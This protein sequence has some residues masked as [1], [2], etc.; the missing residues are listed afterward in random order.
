M[1]HVRLVALAVL[2]G[3]LGG[4]AS[5]LQIQSEH[6]P[7]FDFS[8][9]RTYEWLAVAQPEFGSNTAPEFRDPRFEAEA[10]DPPIR[11]AVDRELAARGYQRVT[12]SDDFLVAYHAALN[13][14][15]L[16][17]S[18]L[19]IETTLTGTVKLRANPLAVATW[20]PAGVGGQAGGS[21]TGLAVRGDCDK[22]AVTRRSP[23]PSPRSTRVVGSCQR[24][25]PPQAAETRVV[26]PESGC[27][28]RASR[29]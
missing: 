19:A 9:V 17:Y 14:S 21:L 25:F 4:C 29:H 6:D 8:S 15:T 12:E 27:G 28:S 18:N 13:R 20:E 1:R 24:V 22:G 10:L 3:A 16:K 11:A 5:S 2:L 7:R 26:P 23:T